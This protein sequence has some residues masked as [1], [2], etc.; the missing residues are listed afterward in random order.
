MFASNIHSSFAPFVAA[1]FGTQIVFG[2]YLKFHWEKGINRYIRKAAI[3]CHGTIGKITPIVS[4]V[5]M[6]FGGITLLG[7]CR[8]DHLGQCLAHGIM[9]SSFIAYGAIMAIM[10]YLGQAWLARRNKSQEFYDS[11][12]IAAWGLVN[13]FTEHRWGSAWSHKDFQHTS[14]GLL[15]CKSC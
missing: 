15:I 10:L 6:G 2:I 8:A 5:Q 11:A 1:V 12:V 14:M 4:W 13:S 7:F 3:L 9:G